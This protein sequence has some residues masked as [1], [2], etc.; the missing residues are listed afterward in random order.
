MREAATKLAIL[1]MVLL[2]PVI[3]SIF[4]LIP[5]L[6]VATIFNAASGYIGGLRLEI[7]EI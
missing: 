7:E 6:I 5:G 2:A 3:Y 4:G 1:S